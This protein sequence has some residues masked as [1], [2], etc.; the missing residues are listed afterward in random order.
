MPVYNDQT[1]ITEAY[2]KV[3][4]KS[5]P[6]PASKRGCK[7]NK[8]NHCKKNQKVD[9]K[10]DAVGKEDSDVDNDGKKSTATD[11]YLLKR[12]AAIAKAKGEK[13]TKNESLQALEKPTFKN[14]YNAV[15]SKR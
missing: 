6:C 1:L 7:C 3:L 14:L 2:E 5:M 10:L 11:K 12:R 15:M 13:E 4:E 9:E 8:C